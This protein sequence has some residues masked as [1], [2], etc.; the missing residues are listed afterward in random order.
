MGALTRSIALILVVFSAASVAQ[1]RP[2]PPVAVIA[3]F[4]DPKMPAGRHKM[5]A[6]SCRAIEAELALAGYDVRLENLYG[7]SPDDLY[8]AVP[9]EGSP[10]VVL[11][12]HGV[13]VNGR[14]LLET[15]PGKTV[16]TSGIVDTLHTINPRTA[17]WTESCFGGAL[18]DESKGRCIGAACRRDEW[19]Y[20]APGEPSLTMK[21]LLELLKLDGKR[22]RDLSG[23]TCEITPKLL[24]AFYEDMLRQ[25]AVSIPLACVV[26][27]AVPDRITPLLQNAPFSPNDRGFGV[28]GRSGKPSGG[29]VKLVGQLGEKDLHDRRR[30]AGDVADDEKRCLDKALAGATAPIEARYRFFAVCNHDHTDRLVLLDDFFPSVQEAQRWMETNVYRETKTPCLVIGTA[31]EKKLV[32]ERAVDR[33]YRYGTPALVLN[34]DKLPEIE[35]PKI[36]Q[37]EAVR[38]FTSPFAGTPAKPRAPDVPTG[39]FT[40]KQAGLLGIVTPQ[41]DDFRLAHPRCLRDDTG[42]SGRSGLQTLEKEGFGH[43]W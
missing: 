12:G 23:G 19:S 10:L 31:Y 13:V 18:A 9:R 7:K 37:D 28:L 24:K 17:L 39:L 26:S 25:A 11:C 6:D 41:L 32:A 43:V 15:A 27:L 3:C 14:H 5:E 36:P 40:A 16:P 8:A 29:G 1:A 42:R 2:A 20:F 38:D 33:R 22:F 35:S 21:P 4:L 34:P 30:P